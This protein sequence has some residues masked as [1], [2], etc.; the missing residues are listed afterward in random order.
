[1]PRMKRTSVAVLVLAP[2]AYGII[3]FSAQMA[4]DRAFDERMRRDRTELTTRLKSHGAS[5][6]QV[7][8]VRAYEAAVS[9][10]V[11]GLVRTTSSASVGALM[12]LGVTL[13]TAMAFRPSDRG[14]QR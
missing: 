9:H 4:G 7:E 5:A 8:D 13:A 6:E 2:L 11:S 14:R 1:L 10:D 3:A 12:F